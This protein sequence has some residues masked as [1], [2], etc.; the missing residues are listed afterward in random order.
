MIWCM[1]NKKIIENCVN[2]TTKIIFANFFPNYIV[3]T[4]LS[5]LSSFRCQQMPKT[6]ISA[7]FLWELCPSFNCFFVS[8][9]QL[10]YNLSIPCKGLYSRFSL[11][12]ISTHIWPVTTKNVQL[13]MELS[14]L[15][16]IIPHFFYVSLLQLNF[17]VDWEI[18]E[19]YYAEKSC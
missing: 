19:S 10:L 15:S 6:G 8:N 12:N 4:R 7:Q 9:L 18:S 16:K 14:N 2:D 5:H 17:Y 3:Q 13:N 1:W 11:V